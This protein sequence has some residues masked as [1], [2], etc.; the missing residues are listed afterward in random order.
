MSSRRIVNASPIIFLHRVGLLDQLN[1]AG[2][3]V[4][5]PVPVLEEPGGLTLDDPAAVL[6]GPLPGSKSRPRR[7]SPTHCDPSDWIGARRPCM[8]IAW[9]RLRKR[10]SSFS[11]T[12]P[13]DDAPRR[14]D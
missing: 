10:P 8:A 5:V 14:W 12:S 1:E 4:L 11:T 6:R 2:V 9:C 3:T 13:P 7:L